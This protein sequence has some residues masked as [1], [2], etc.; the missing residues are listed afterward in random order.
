M[1]Q[2][3]PIVAEELR[4]LDDASERLGR[5]AGR[6]YASEDE[7]IGELQ[8]IQEQ[9]RGGKSD[10][11]SAFEQQY[12]HLLRLLEQLR[13]GRP[14][15]RPD[16]LSPYFAHMRLNTDG[17]T[18]DVLLG[19][20]TCLEDGLRIVDWRH[21]PVSRVY[22]RYQEGDDYEEEFGER[23]VEGRLVARRSVSIRQGELERVTCPQG[24]FL[25]EGATWS[26]V[27]QAPPRL[28][29]KPEKQTGVGKSAFST[30]KA[31]RQDKHLPDIAA[32][33]DPEQFE[34]ISKADS[35]PVV[36]RGGAGS[37]KTT[38]ALHR[39]AW[40]AYQTPGRFPPHKMLVVVWGRALRDYVGKVLPSL[41]VQGV[42]VATWSDMSRA[43]VKRHFPGLPSH[44]N[45]NTPSVVSRIKLHPELPRL[46]EELIRGRQAP[47]TGASAIEDWKALVGDSAILGKLSGIPPQDVQTAILWA[48]SQQA[49][50][51]ARADGDKTAET[52]LDDE[53]DAL[54]LRA[55]QLRVGNMKARDGSQVRFSHIAVDEVQDFS[56]ME[57][58]VL[59][60]M[61][62]K[63]Q[64]ITLSGD[65]QQ[66][67][68]EKGGSLRWQ[69]LL[70]GLGIASTELST[71][72]ISY[73][74]TAPIAAFS[75]AV[76][77]PL[78]EEESAPETMRDG[79]AVEV[80]TFAEHGA[81]VDALGIALRTL[82]REEPKA[83]V[84]LVAL[85]AATA[86]LY[87]DGLERM[88]I[89]E[90][91]LVEEEEFAFAP[92]VDCVDVS[93][94]K[95]LE[96]DYVVVVGASLGV[97]SARPHHRRL[98]HVAATRAVHQLWVTCI[99][100]PCEAV[101][102]ALA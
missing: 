41:G 95:G 56:P 59:F 10:D 11:K 89:P 98:L 71:L 81:C 23:M 93:Q 68:M 19:K 97:W 83:S 69:D 62:D 14:T 45:A 77:G 9:I 32:L 82:L 4:L 101:Q 28:A 36:I 90:L 16:P 80:M 21:A 65:T 8:H 15:E 70:L 26:A 17:R 64:C 100:E 25:K 61:C 78:A 48:R 29:P 20:A 52:W 84:A 87:H 63:H 43:L 3:P 66:H 22:Y 6:T 94:V 39:I 46:L 2:T 33:I 7:I 51:A 55:W 58:A 88:E 85:D 34:L 67:I 73:R 57:I 30:G 38:V 18:F 40:L 102:E 35:G 92:G 1:A 75:R 47:P 42:G 13:R 99:G 72:R 76:L 49:Q 60:G 24:S 79:P 37:G 91:R 74:S 86:R 53:D 50:L 27:S 96:F 44:A 31:L 5:A 12:E 54:L